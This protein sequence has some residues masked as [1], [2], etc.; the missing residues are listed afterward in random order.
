[1]RQQV[2]DKLKGLALTSY[3]VTEELPFDE[4]DNPLYIKNPKR[5][6]IDNTQTAQEPLIVALDGLNIETTTE[7]VTVYFTVDAKNVPANYETAISS[8]KGIKDTVT[9]NGA[10]QR[11]V[12]VSTSYTND[13]LINELEYTFT[14]IT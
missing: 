7:S 9:S 6:Y 12:A 2:I 5:I 10:T 14:R 1:M 8:M 4:S 3:S 11:T 13:L